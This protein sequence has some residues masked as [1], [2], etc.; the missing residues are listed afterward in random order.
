M[1]FGVFIGYSL[2]VAADDGVRVKPAVLQWPRKSVQGEART[3][4][5]NVPELFV[6][7]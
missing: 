2:D 4:Y 7:E 1:A 6:T 3:V 5:N